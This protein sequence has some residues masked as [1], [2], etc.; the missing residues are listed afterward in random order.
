MC[1]SAA[2]GDPNQHK[3]KSKADSHHSSAARVALQLLDDEDV[4]TRRSRVC[5]AQTVWMCGGC[6]M[7]SSWLE[8]CCEWRWVTKQLAGA[9]AAVGWLR[10]LGFILICELDC[11]VAAS[12]GDVSWL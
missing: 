12:L 2:A 11:K 3:E 9:A 7:F 8:L 5:G 10:E 6:L 1:P 4:I